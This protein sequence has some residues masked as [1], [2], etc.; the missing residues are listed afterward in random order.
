M[1]LT[2]PSIIDVG[3][4]ADLMSTGQ[5][6]LVTSCASSIQVVSAMQLPLYEVSG[7]FLTQ[8]AG[9][10]LHTTRTKYGDEPLVSQKVDNKEQVEADTLSSGVQASS[11]AGPGSQSTSCMVRAFPMLP[12]SVSAPRTGLPP[13]MHVPLGG[14]SDRFPVSDDCNAYRDSI[15]ANSCNMPEVVASQLIAPQPP[16]QTQVRRRRLCGSGY[17]ALSRCSSVPSMPRLTPLPGIGTASKAPERTIDTEAVLTEIRAMGKSSTSRSSKKSNISS[18]EIRLLVRK[19]VEAAA[20]ALRS[21]CCREQA[22]R[23]AAEKAI[24]QRSSASCLLP[25]MAHVGLVC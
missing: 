20:Q 6:P 21:E 4:A 24:L 25:P 11:E 9:S 22:A 18:E 10:D 17:P 1:S 23:E 16:R 12:I 2:G 8:V 19:R 3:G 15:V 14:R 13:P 5:L 7:A